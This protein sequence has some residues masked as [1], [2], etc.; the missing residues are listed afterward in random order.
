[1]V[2]DRIDLSH[3]TL[4]PDGT[5]DRLFAVGAVIGAI[6]ALMIIVFAGCARVTA[7][8]PDGYAFDQRARICVPGVEPEYR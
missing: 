2:S 6:V 3:S 1:M 8:C 4:P 5:A 7:H